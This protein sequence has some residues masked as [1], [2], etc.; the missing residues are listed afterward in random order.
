VCIE[1]SETH[2]GSRDVATVRLKDELMAISRRA[3]CLPR[4]TGR[5]PEEIIGYDER[6]LPRWW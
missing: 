1:C 2:R 3:S 6:R 4:R 5:T